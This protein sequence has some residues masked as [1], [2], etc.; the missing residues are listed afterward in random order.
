MVQI[1]HTKLNHSV[2]RYKKPIVLFK[3]KYFW[4]WQIHHNLD[5]AKFYDCGES[6]RWVQNPFKSSEKNAIFLAY[7][8]IF[9]LTWNYNRNQK[10]F[11]KDVKTW[12]YFSIL[13]VFKKPPLECQKNVE[14]KLSETIKN[15]IKPH[16]SHWKYH[17]QL[18]EMVL[19]C[20]FLQ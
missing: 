5:E 11:A 2:R 6:Y 1:Y 12:W 14:K 9:N 15:N 16:G 18:N 20:H 4:K 17:I 8:I 13:F 7:T 3:R 19:N 10:S